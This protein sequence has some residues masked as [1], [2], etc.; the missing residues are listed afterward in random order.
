MCLFIDRKKT[1]KA[2]K[3]KT[4]KVVRWKVLRS[5]SCLN[6]MCKS[7]TWKPGYNKSDRQ[8][9]GLSMDEN[10]FG[11]VDKG[12]HVSTSRAMARTWLFYNCSRLVKVVCYNKDLVA[13][14]N[15]GDEVYTRVFLSKDEYND[16]LKRK[17][18]E[19]H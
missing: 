19:K 16:A 14:G 15:D 12:F 6:S 11:R 7:H 9:L 13:V 1:T 8:T 17:G 2:K 18:K 3:N 10:I 5:D 4:G